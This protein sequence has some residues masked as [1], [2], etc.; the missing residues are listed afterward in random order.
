MKACP[1]CAEQIQDAAIVC[2]WCGR[3][4]PVA[5]TPASV[6]TPAAPPTIAAPPIAGPE[7]AGGAASA[8]PDAPYSSG[9]ALGAGLLTFFMP[10]IAVVVAL[11]M[12]GSETRPSRRKFLSTWAT[13][14]G[15]WL[16][17][18]F[19]IVVLALGSFSGGGGCKGGIDEFGIP[20]YEST[21][22]EHWIAIYPCVDGGST[23]TPVDNPFPET[24][25]PE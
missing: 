13:A 21:D 16:A 5:G 9:M 19:L 12:R 3:D 20:R 17:T 7:P 8:P 4:L 6:G 23:R 22:N 14:S 25:A 10:F 15:V 11:V 18:G 24:S 1:Y 2:R